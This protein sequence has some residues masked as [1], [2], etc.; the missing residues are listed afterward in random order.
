MAQLAKRAVMYVLL[1]CIK[2]C[3]GL[4]IQCIEDHPQGVVTL[5]WQSLV[6]QNNHECIHSRISIRRRNIW[7]DEMDTKPGKSSVARWFVRSYFGRI[8]VALLMITIIQ[9]YV[10]W[11]IANSYQREQR[12]AE[13]I[14]ALGGTVGIEHDRPAW[15]PQSIQRSIAGF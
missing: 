6:E 1:P 4:S 13:Q 3:R 10:I 14:I 5:N 15:I 9:F 8:A 12:T 2:N 11:R 7:M